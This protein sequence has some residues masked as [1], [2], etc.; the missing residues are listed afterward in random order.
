MVEHVFLC[1]LWRAD[2]GP[3]PSLLKE[4]W[5]VG[6]DHTG[7][8]EKWEK[9]GVAG[10]ISL[11]TDQTPLFL[12]HPSGKQRVE[13]SGLRS[14]VEPQKGRKKGG[15]LMFV[16]FSVLKSILT[17]NKLNYFSTN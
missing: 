13:K 17:G 16:C 5:S 1:S 12:P 8:G 15:V 2:A 11:Y 10:R 4:L 6:R 14:E 3:V 7:A 9:E